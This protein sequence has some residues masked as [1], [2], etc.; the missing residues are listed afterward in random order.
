MELKSLTKLAW[1][2]NHDDA[3]GIYQG[4]IG[5]FGKIVLKTCFWTVFQMYQQTPHL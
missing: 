2:Q 1:T 5:E 3:S 4:A